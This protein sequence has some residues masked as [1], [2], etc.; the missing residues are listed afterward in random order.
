MPKN[1]WSYRGGFL[2]FGLIAGLAT[3]LFLMA[4]PVRA[5]GG[6]IRVVDAQ[7]EINY[8]SGVGLTVTVESEAEVDEVRVYYRAAGSRQWGYAYAE[9]DPGTRIVAQQSIPVQEATYIAPGADVEYYYEVRDVLGNVL[10]TDRT[11]VEYLDPRFEWRR[12]DI[13]PLQLLYHDIDDSRIEE[14]SRVL[15]DDLRRVERVLQIEQS[16][17]FKGVIYKSYAVA[18]AAFPVQSQTTTDHGT[19]GGYAFPEQRV[20]VGQGLDR[21]I[22]VH[23]SVHMMLHEA[24]GDRV[25]ELPDW[26]NEGFATYMEPNV[27]IMDSSQL[28]RR[29]PHLKAMKNL[30]GTPDTIPLFYQ[31]SVSVVA[32]L[33]EEYGLDKFRLLLEEIGRGRT[34]DVALINVYGFDDHGLDSSWAGFPIPDITASTKERPSQSRATAPTKELRS[35]SQG[36]SP[37]REPVLSSE[38]RRENVSES[39]SQASVLDRETASPEERSPQP[40]SGSDRS[41]DDQLTAQPQQE[42]PQENEGPSPFIF[43]DTWILA[44]V[45]I[46]AIIALSGRFAYSRLRRYRDDA[47]SMDNGWY[48]DS[49]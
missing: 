31:K 46:L 42:E 7:Q 1:A 19:F 14:A 3:V 48:R 40:Q 18:N 45:A 25:V 26:L 32:H 36:T 22:I 41:G 8:P 49:T 11:V 28:Y 44:G 47:E 35:Q 15:I 9:F 2:L 12:V 29:T 39:E 30:S 27:R 13:G 16:E 20:F 24:L 6:E 4:F 34:T 5:S 38:P 37:T 21:R 23:E 17:G 43:F 10:R 33:I